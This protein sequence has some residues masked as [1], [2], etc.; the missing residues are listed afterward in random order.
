MPTAER[1]A[2]RLKG[3]GKATQRTR[4]SDSRD[5]AKRLKGRGKAALGTPPIINRWHPGCRLLYPLAFNEMRLS[6]IG[7]QISQ[8]G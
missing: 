4:Q 6:P 3:R 8:L 2:K 7:P 5:A 1:P